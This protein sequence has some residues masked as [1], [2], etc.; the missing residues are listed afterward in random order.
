MSDETIQALR[1]ALTHSPDNVPLRLH[2]AQLLLDAKTLD[3]AIEYLAED[4]L[5]EV[6]PANYRIRKKILNTE[7]RGRETKRKKVALAV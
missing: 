7:H 3:E 5:L 6:T 1:E 2:V 4:E